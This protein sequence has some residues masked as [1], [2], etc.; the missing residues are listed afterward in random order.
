[1][2]TSKCPECGAEVSGQFM[3]QIRFACNSEILY[4]DGPLVRSDLCKL[5]VAER[6]RDAWRDAVLYRLIALGIH[7]PAD[8]ANPI[9]AVHRLMATVERERDEAD[10]KN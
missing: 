8:D 6:E 9:N 3:G 10:I 2:N 7:T 1:M 5:T 4:E